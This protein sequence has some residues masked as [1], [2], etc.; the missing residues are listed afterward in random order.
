M[1][2]VAIR[3]LTHE[4][5]LSAEEGDALFLDPGALLK[6]KEALA[7]D[8]VKAVHAFLLNSGDPEQKSVLVMLLPSTNG[9]VNGVSGFTDGEGE[10]KTTI[11]SIFANLRQPT[12]SLSDGDR[13]NR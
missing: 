2:R 3:G 8:A 6:L 12:L 7:G 1:A 11:S 10:V 9:M 4:L 13:G 5:I